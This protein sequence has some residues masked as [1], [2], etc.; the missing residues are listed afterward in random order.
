LPDADSIVDYLK[1]EMKR[2][3]V[4][5]VMSNGGFGGIHDKLIDVLKGRSAA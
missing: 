4:I 2:G 1:P 5:A 3:D